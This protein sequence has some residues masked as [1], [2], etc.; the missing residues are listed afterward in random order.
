MPAMANIVVNDGATTPVAHTFVPNGFR[1][2][3]ALFQERSA[4][5]PQGY[6]DLEIS[7][8]EPTPKGSVYR[9]QTTLKIPVL[10]TTLDLAGNSITSVDY[11]HT[12]K[13]EWLEPVK[14]TT[15]NRKDARAISY[16]LLNNADIRKVVEDLERMW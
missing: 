10:K 15:Q 8:V 14:G 3:T 1:G 12:V 13:Q 5:T 11:V 6:W 9:V 16:N 2:N 7:L 4:A